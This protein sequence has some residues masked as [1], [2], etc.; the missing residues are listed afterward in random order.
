MGNFDLIRYT[1]FDSWIPATDIDGIDA[2]PSILADVSNFRFRNGFME[3]V[4]QFEQIDL[5]DAFADD[6]KNGDWELLS[7]C[8]FTHSEQGEQMLY[9][10]WKGDEPAPEDRLRLFLGSNELDLDEQSAGLA[11]SDK[12]NNINY[13][14]V[15][16][17]LKINLNCNGDYGSTEQ[18][19]LNLTLIYLEDVT[20]NSSVARLAGWY[21]FPRWLG[22][23][24]T[25]DNTYMNWIEILQT[26]ITTANAADYNLWYSGVVVS[27]GIFS[28]NSGNASSLTIPYL[29][30][31]GY[32]RLEMGNWMTC[33]GEVT[34]II[35]RDDEEVGS[36]TMD[37]SLANGF[38]KILHI[39][40]NL[41][42]KIQP[43]LSAGV[44]TITRIILSGAY[45][46]GAIVAKYVDGQRGLLRSF[47]GNYEV[48]FDLFDSFN[49]TI[50]ENEIDWRI[51]SY[52]IYMQDNPDSD[53]LM[54]KQVYNVE[55]GGWNYSSPLLTFP[56]SLLE[57]DLVET[58][59]FNYGLPYDTR[60]DNQR[61]IYSET[62]HKGRVYF[63][64]GDYRVY[65]S[66]IA[67]NIA[68]QA[69]SFPYQED[70]GY[71]YFIV[72]RSQKMIG[73]ATSPSNDLI[74]FS[75]SRIYIYFIQAG[76]RGAY[77]T[78]RLLTGNTGLSSLKS[79]TREL[80]GSPS[81][82]GLFWIDHNGLY[83]YPGGITNPVNLI[84]GTHEEYWKSIPDSS[85]DT[86][87]GFYNPFTKE[88]WLS[89]GANLR[90]IFE[91]PY[92]NFYKAS[93][94]II[95]EF[96]GI[97]NSGLMYRSGGLI[98]R[99]D[100]VARLAAQAYTHYSTAEL[101]ELENKILQECY[102]IFGASEKADV[103]LH[104]YYDDK[105]L[106][107]NTFDSSRPFDKYLL[108]YGVKFNRVKLEVQIVQNGK[109]VFIKEFGVS[110]SKDSRMPLGSRVVDAP[111]ETGFGSEFGTE[112]GET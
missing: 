65:Q 77:K 62:E 52:E 87:V 28:F 36:Y 84:L 90:L 39:G 7:V 35:Y 19:I 72:N 81:T 97:S 74:I 103:K 94:T 89:I 48:G 96:I 23:L 34:I 15:N 104:I 33:V 53:V 55:D 70:V 13:N 4:Y 45:P 21:C 106:G 102:M 100:S 63:V 56:T 37:A 83:Y 60:V 22:A 38:V 43:N 79:L 82:D 47:G 108:P 93:H 12:P 50:S 66:H 8:V 88:Y 44:L 109:K 30:S 10:L 101:P 91:I 59:N 98:K 31:I 111:P 107:Y 46:K 6:V 11:F 17:Q 61:L 42:I 76:G 29:K 112:F 41:S 68:I 2:K 110:Y 5:P 73:I 14:F 40:G 75:K 67:S 86:A 51:I 78:L 99:Q 49:F 57:T 85:K 16:D 105:Y 80:D 25:Y 9:V 26:Q 27:T 32:I 92:K 24:Q 20:Y 95:D 58:L 18:V 3:N 69:D 1:G 54:L 71:G 64:N